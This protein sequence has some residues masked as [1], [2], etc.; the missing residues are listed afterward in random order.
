MLI[1][2]FATQIFLY[3]TDTTPSAGP[4]DASHGKLSSN[5]NRRGEPRQVNVNKDFDTPAL[6]T[7]PLP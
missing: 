5:N 4:D 6:V 1:S 2:V 7:A 3:P